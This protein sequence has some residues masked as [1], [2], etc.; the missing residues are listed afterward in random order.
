VQFSR[1]CQDHFSH[2]GFKNAGECH[3]WMLTWASLN[4]Q[5]RKF[6]LGTDIRTEAKDIWRME[7]V[8]GGRATEDVGLLIKAA[9][10]ELKRAK[11]ELTE[12]QDEVLALADN[13]IPALKLNLEIARSTR[14]AIVREAKESLAAMGD[15]RRFFLENDY[16]TE[17]ERLKDFM[18]TIDRLKA[19]NCN[20][21]LNIM[22][23]TLLKLAEG[24]HDGGK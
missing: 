17:M 24:N 20:G 7:A 8:N 5:P 2:H 16:Q 6:Y 18:Q 11:K 10:E 3:Y 15:L 12:L 1:L 13:L 23:D 21:T 9:S 4:K 19:L 14:M 22:A